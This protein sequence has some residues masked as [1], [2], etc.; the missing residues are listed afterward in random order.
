MCCREGQHP[1]AHHGPRLRSPE[2]TP[3]LEAVCRPRPPAGRTQPPAAVA[4]APEAPW[5]GLT[6]PRL[7]VWSAAPTRRP[8][9]AADTSPGQRPQRQAPVSGEETQAE[10]WLRAR[11]AEA[12]WGPP[13]A[14]RPSRS[15]AGR[16][17]APPCS[18]LSSAVGVGVG[19]APQPPAGGR[20][21]PFPAQQALKPPRVPG[22]QRPPRGCADSA[23]GPAPAG[24]VGGHSLCEPAHPGWAAPWLGRRPALP[25]CGFVP[26][27]GHSVANVVFG[28]WNRSA[29]LSLPSSLSKTHEHTLEKSFLLSS[30]GEPPAATLG[31]NRAPNPPPGNNAPEV[32]SGLARCV[33]RS[34]PRFC[35]CAQGWRTQGLWGPGPLA[36]RRNPCACPAGGPHPQQPPQRLSPQAAQGSKFLGSRALTVNPGP[37]RCVGRKDRTPGG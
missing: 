15:P 30:P 9:V 28:I 36:A 17:S 2:R 22:A 4:Q 23:P 7:R 25:G 33:W 34:P 1:W 27:V 5:A 8:T 11:A 6:V 29:I 12:G 26:Q 10:T 13:P 35:M 19:C 14:P 31:A 16:P 24:T 21:H 20:P 18:T 3:Q 37:Q 32:N